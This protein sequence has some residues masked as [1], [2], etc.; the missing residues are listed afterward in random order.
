L[1]SALGMHRN[2]LRKKIK[3]AGINNQF[4]TLSDTQPD[5]LTWEY[6]QK[7]PTSG[8]RYLQ[9]HFRRQGLRMQ[10]EWTRL[11]LKRVDGYKVPR[12]NHLWHLDG[13]H[14]LIWWGFIIHSFI[15]G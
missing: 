9:G 13:H 14:K 5:R 12:P 8:R 10:R 11:S 6:K 3:E 7:K 4:A 15:D 1:A 2:I